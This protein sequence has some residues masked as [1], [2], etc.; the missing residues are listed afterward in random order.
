MYVNGVVKREH[1]S[2]AQLEQHQC[3][4]QLG[5]GA[6]PEDRVGVNRGPG[7]KRGETDTRQAQVVEQRTYE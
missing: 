4:D 6:H 5:H 1:A 7:G 2:I 3:S